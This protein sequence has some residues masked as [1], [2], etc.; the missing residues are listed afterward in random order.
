[1]HESCGYAF[2]QDSSHD[3]KICGSCSKNESR[4]SMKRKLSLESS[5]QPALKYRAKY[6][7][8]RDSLQ[9][10]KVLPEGSQVRVAVP[11]QHRTKVDK[12][13]LR[14]VILENKT[15]GYKVGTRRGVIRT[16]I[17]FDMVEDVN[18]RANTEDIIR[19]IGVPTATRTLRAIVLQQSLGRPGNAY[20]KCTCKKGNCARCLCRQRGHN[21]TSH[22]LCSRTSCTNNKE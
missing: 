8:A 21:C 18:V 7:Q 17:P 5:R 14:G 13:C 20:S 1:M 4:L 12:R 15:S 19:S 3:S 16:A 10:A 2:E 22:C 11:S 9:S 6:E